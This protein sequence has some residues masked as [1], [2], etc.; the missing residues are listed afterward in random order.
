[1]TASGK[2][3]CSRLLKNPS[4]AGGFSLFHKP[5]LSFYRC[6]SL[7]RP[8]C[9]CLFLPLAVKKKRR[10]SCSSS[11]RS[12]GV[13]VSEAAAEQQ[14][15]VCHVISR[16]ARV[17]EHQPGKWKEKKGGGRRSEDVDGGASLS[18]SLSATFGP[19]KVTRSG[20]S[21]DSL[22]FFLL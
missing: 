8:R 19:G 1:M 11:S 15:D 9:R 12:S 4:A 10:S 13:E 18:A 2:K 5:A 16:L 17:W 22:P 14:M 6:C 7:M 21:R 3:T 20:V